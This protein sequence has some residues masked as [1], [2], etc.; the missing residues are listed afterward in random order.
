[1]FQSTSPMSHAARC[2]WWS[3]TI[4]PP[5]TS[6]A[7][8]LRGLLRLASGEA[9][10]L[11]FAFRIRIHHL[12]RTQIAAHSP[13]TRGSRAD[14]ARTTRNCCPCR[15]LC[16]C[17]PWGGRWADT[18]MPSAMRAFIASPQYRQALLP[19]HASPSRPSAIF[20]I[21]SF[22]FCRSRA[23]S[24]SKGCFPPALTRST[25]MPPTRPTTSLRFPVWP[26]PPPARQ[27]GMAVH[28]RHADRQRILEPGGT[29][30]SGG[31][32]GRFTFPSR[33]PSRVGRRPK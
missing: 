10:D 7:R 12:R 20:F 29:L 21:F 23:R 8:S 32:N 33:D 11:P 27:G 31:Y 22:F 2:P 15:D 1:M 18:K 3:D 14:I 30:A 24:V 26:M 25:I 9:R 17:P 5:T 19:S 13:E 16:Q 6:H 4:P 28:R